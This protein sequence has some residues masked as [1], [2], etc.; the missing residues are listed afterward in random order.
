M[1]KHLELA[2]FLKTRRDKITPEQVG[3]P[4][5]SR[6]RTPGL[7]RE[8]VAQLAG[9]GITWYTWL[10]QGRDIKVSQQVL[11]SLARVLQFTNQERQHLFMLA[12]KGKMHSSPVEQNVITPALKNLLD[13]VT[14]IPAYII[15]QRWNLLAWNNISA[16]VFGDFSSLIQA[17]RN[18]VYLMFNNQDYMELF[19]DWEFHARGVIAR[20]R[21][22]Y[23]KY[24]DDRWM[25]EFV[26]NQCNANSLFEEWWAIHDVHAMEDVIKEINHPKV[27]RMVYEFVSLDVS[28]NPNLKLIFHNP[29]SGT[30]T[31]S[32]IAQLKGLG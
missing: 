14:D 29:V 20:F 32:K 11:D 1:D 22:T 23:G 2:H 27:G 5:G 16:Q 28:A 8:E 3:L 7:R 21:A 9:V 26:Q 30:G 15:D 19:E 18:I 10:E 12:G 31:R 25:Q 13:N 17:E 4:H 24:Q 6:R